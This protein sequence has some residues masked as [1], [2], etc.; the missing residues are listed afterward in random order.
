MGED[1]EINYKENNMATTNLTTKT[2]K[3]TVRGR[4][5]GN[6]KKDYVLSLLRSAQFKTAKKTNSVALVRKDRS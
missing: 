1:L 2:K 4:I 5:N 3:H 6:R